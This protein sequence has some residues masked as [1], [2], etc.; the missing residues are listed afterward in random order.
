MTWK[1]NTRVDLIEIGN[2]G[3]VAVRYQCNVSV[4]CIR[5]EEDL[6]S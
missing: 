4:D 1:Y 5:G 6:T 2:E 3:T